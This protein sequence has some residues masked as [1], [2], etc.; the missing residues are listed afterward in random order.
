MLCLAYLL[1]CISTLIISSLLINLSLSIYFYHSCVLEFSTFAQ[2]YPSTPRV[3]TSLW[4]KPSSSS[5][6][7]I[8][9]QRLI[10]NYCKKYLH[11]SLAT[12]LSPTTAHVAG[13]HSTFLAMSL[14]ASNFLFWLSKH[15]HHIE[16]LIFHT[17]CQ[18]FVEIR[19][20]WLEAIA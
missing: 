14:W 12:R 3:S 19:G 9:A 4:V 18:C 15:V 6:R 13:V 16:L 5:F 8:W 11:I 10:S 1:I 20:Y 2:R 7:I 17:P